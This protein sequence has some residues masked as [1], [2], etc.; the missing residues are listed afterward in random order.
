MRPI[1][2]GFSIIESV[3]LHYKIFISKS[4][5]MI[6][7]GTVTVSYSLGEKSS[8]AVPTPAPTP[9]RKRA[10]AKLACCVIFKTKRIVF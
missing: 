1:K 4:V 9:A 7:T 6:M 2:N 10:D 5:A 3:F 8:V